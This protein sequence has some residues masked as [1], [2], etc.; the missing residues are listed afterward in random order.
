MAVAVKKGKPE[1]KG[2]V[3]RTAAPKRG[4]KSVGKAPPK[5]AARTKGK[6]KGAS[7]R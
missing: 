6:A 1:T 5:K 7:R 2:T 3:K 4:A